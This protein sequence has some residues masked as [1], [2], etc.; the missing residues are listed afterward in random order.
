MQG[1]VAMTTVYLFTGCNIT[2]HGCIVCDYVTTNFD[3][4]RFRV[5]DVV[6]RLR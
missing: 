2:L 6:G 3:M 5:E 4:I 1:K